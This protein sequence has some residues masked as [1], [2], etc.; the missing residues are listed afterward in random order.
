MKRCFKHPDH[1]HTHT[2]THTLSLPLW[3]RVSVGVATVRVKAADG[4]VT[5]SPALVF[6]STVQ[7]GISSS[8]R[9]HLQRFLFWKLTAGDGASSGRARSFCTWLKDTMLYFWIHTVWIPG[10]AF[11]FGFQGKGSFLSFHFMS[12]RFPLGNTGVEREMTAS[13]DVYCASVRLML[14]RVLKV[15]EVTSW[16]HLTWQ[17]DLLVAGCSSRA[18]C[19]LNK[20]SAEWSW[21]DSSLHVQ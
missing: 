6:I 7:T 4:A 5:E 18:V 13:V 19:A 3:R 11:L 21:S 17:R 1:T 9:L 8:A 10:V 15:C 20:V 14:T 12:W 16:K 2:H